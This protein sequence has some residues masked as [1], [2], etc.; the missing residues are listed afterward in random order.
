MK[1][2]IISF[3]GPDLVETLTPF[4]IG[5]W[6]ATG[7]VTTENGDIQKH[8]KR[9]STVFRETE[10]SSIEEQLMDCFVQPGR[11]VFIGPKMGGR[12]I[13]HLIEKCG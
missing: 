7:K 13:F 8:N 10:E 12:S 5:Q 11:S 6:S 4:I 1:N 2:F 9:F 3:L